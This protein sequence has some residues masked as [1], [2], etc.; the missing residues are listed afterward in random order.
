[1]LMRTPRRS[2]PVLWPKGATLRV[3]QSCVSTVKN[4]RTWVNL[5]HSTLCG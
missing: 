4:S 2:R 5:L 1:M 3:S